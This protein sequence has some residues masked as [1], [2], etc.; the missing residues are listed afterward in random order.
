MATKRRAAW[1]LIAQAILCTSVLAASS[2]SREARVDSASGDWGG[3]RL[4]VRW[5][6]SRH[7][8][9]RPETVLFV[10][11]VDAGT[12]V[13]VFDWQ[14]RVCGTKGVRP[15]GVGRS[16]AL[17]L[18]GA[19]H[20]NISSTL[21]PGEWDALVFPR[22]LPPDEPLD[23]ADDCVARIKL[24]TYPPGDELELTLPAP[25]PAPGKRE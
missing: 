21:G 15:G 10:E 14:S 23:S 12:L 2:S 6:E 19:D 8:T 20:L 9:Y 7:S 18:F 25:L 4:H 24:R 5:R 11:N 1:V 22:G 13:V 3:D 16:F 17:E